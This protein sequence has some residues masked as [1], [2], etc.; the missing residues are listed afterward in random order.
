MRRPLLP[1]RTLATVIAGF[2]SSAMWSRVMLI[3]RFTL[4][5]LLLL[6]TVISV[7]CVIVAQ[8]FRG[9]AWAIGCFA[10]RSL[11]GC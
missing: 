1:C 2:A 6:I 3:P 9:Q 7:F 5:W 11:S 4:R 8:A 10:G